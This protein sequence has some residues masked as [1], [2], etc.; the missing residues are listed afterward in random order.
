MTFIRLVRSGAAVVLMGVAAVGCDPSDVAGVSGPG[1][2]EAKNISDAQFDQTIAKG[3]A[4]VDFWAPWC[5]PC[6]EQGPI[7]EQVAKAVGARA[8][9]AKV[10]VDENG[11][12]AAKFNVT[13]IPTLIVFKDGKQVRRFEGVQSKETLLQTIEEAL[14]K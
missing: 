14:G 13:A 9:V 1:A 5:P 12:T 2:S 3:V 11:A 7:V 6:R 8:T 10:S 4:L